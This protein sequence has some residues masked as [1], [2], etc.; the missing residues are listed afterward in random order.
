[1]TKNRL[2]ERGQKN[3]G[4]GRP[5][6]LIRAMPERKRFFFHWGLPLESIS[7]ELRR[8]EGQRKS[9][10]GGYLVSKRSRRRECECRGHSY[11]HWRIAQCLVTLNNLSSDSWKL[12]N[13]G[14]L[15][16]SSD[17]DRKVFASILFRVRSVF[18]LSMMS[19][20]PQYNGRV[21]TPILHTWIVFVI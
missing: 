2:L 5:P 13:F 15:E 10:F 7:F 1:M 20:V 11:I 16:I 4:M 12:Q 6:P 18:V 19:L 3:S 8:Q 14:A 9:L 21:S 17:F